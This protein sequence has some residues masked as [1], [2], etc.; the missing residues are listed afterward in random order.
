MINPMTINSRGTCWNCDS[1]KFSFI[2]SESNTLVINDGELEYEKESTI[3]EYMVCHNCGEM[4]NVYKIGNNYYPSSPLKDRL[5]IP[6]YI[7]IEPEYK[8]KNPF[9]KENN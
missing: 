1:K 9:Y 7:Q 3:E 8:F 2:T 6:Q 4:F 5:G